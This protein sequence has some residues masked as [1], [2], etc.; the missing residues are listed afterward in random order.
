MLLQ[1]PSEYQNISIIV[2]MVS[3]M[4][5]NEWFVE[6]NDEPPHSAIMVQ[7]ITI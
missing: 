2:C 4:I 7:Y 6:L 5:Y 3:R 1:L